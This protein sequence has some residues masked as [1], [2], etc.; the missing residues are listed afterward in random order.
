MTKK[1]S[2]WSNPPPPDTPPPEQPSQSPLFV[3]WRIGSREEVEKHLQESST[4]LYRALFKT[5]VSHIHGREIPMAVILATLLDLT[6]DLLIN[7]GQ[8]WGPPDFVA[9]LRK[10]ASELEERRKQ[11]PPPDVERALGGLSAKPEDGP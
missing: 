1:P 5:V 4:D 9:A 8:L 7:S 6:N 3:Q 2:G 11:P 10:G